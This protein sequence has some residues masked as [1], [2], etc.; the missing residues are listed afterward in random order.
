MNTKTDISN[1]NKI[2]RELYSATFYKKR[3][4]KDLDTIIDD[5]AHHYSTFQKIIKDIFQDSFSFEFKGGNILFNHLISARDGADRITF[6]Y[7]TYRDNFEQRF[8]SLM[9]S[10][11]FSVDSYPITFCPNEAP[12]IRVYTSHDDI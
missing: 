5:V 2:K 1:L 6:N 8:T 11:A 12:D 7:S 4:D 10:G 9:F 3:E